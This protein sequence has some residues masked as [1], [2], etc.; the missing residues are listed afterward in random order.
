[1]RLPSVA[2]RRVKAS[3]SED[4]VPPDALTASTSCST[5]ASAFPPLRTPPRMLRGGVGGGSRRA[6]V[7]SGE[8]F[9]MSGIEVEIGSRFRGNHRAEDEG[10]AQ[11]VGF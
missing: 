7:D 10:L 3:F 6:M 8:G 5:P 11:H 1:M 4:S 9:E 2:S